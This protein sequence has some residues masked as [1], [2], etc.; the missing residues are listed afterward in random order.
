MSRQ[1]TK[2]LAS[3]SLRLFFW[4]ASEDAD[5]EVMLLPTVEPDKVVSKEERTIGRDM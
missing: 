4:L 1:L 5:C 3:S 2:D